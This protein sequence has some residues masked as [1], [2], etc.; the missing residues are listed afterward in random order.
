MRI[1][2]ETSS[3]GVTE[4]LLALGELPGV[5]WTPDGAEGP[6]PLILMGHGGGQ[7]KKPPDIAA[8]ARRFGRGRLRGRGARRAGHG[9]RP[10]DEK[11]AR[12]AAENQARVDGGADRAPLIAAFQAL[13][14]DQVVPEWQRA[15][16][17]IQELDYVGAGPAGYWGV[18]LGCGL[19]VPFVAA[20]PRVR[21]AVP[22]LG[23]AFAPDGPAARI[24]V[25][26]LFLV[27]WDGVSA[28]T[29][30]R[31]E[32]PTRPDHHLVRPSP[33]R[34]HRIRPGTHGTCSM[35]AP[36]TAQRS[37]GSEVTTRRF[38]CR[39]Q[40]ATETSTTSAWPDLPQSRPTARAT[41]SSRATTSVRSSLSRTAIRACR[42]PPRH[43][44]ATAP[45]GTAT[46]QS[47]RSISSSS[48]C[49]RLL[50]RSIAISAPA[51]KVIA[52]VIRLPA[53][54]EPTRNHPRSAARP[55]PAYQQPG[56]RLSGSAPTAP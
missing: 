4:Q 32:R 54:A 55:R 30:R 26:V 15:L 29:T 37:P 11:D 3:G 23:G 16:D 7:H 28:S 5:L 40:R 47:R 22:G 18:S 13:V 1:T 46:C 9:G 8:H 48:A 6:R 49:I 53:P 50:R 34:S 44:W 45:A 51:S 52:L 38:R 41:G 31:N 19:G 2:S 56:A 43:A 27:R 21:A 35:S 33:T 24:T 39:A 14:A 17:A 12:I 25:P 20:E 42:G 36:S 10:R